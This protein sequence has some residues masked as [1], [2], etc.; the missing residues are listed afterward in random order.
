MNLA[1]GMWAV[2]EADELPRGPAFSIQ[3]IRLEPKRGSRASEN[4]SPAATP[5]PEPTAGSPEKTA[6]EKRSV[7]PAPAAK[8]LRKIPG[9]SRLLTYELPGQAWA[10]TLDP[11]VGRLTLAV[12]GAGFLAYDLTDLLNARLKPKRQLSADGF[13][14][15][16]VFKVWE[17]KRLVL[18]ATS[19]SRGI[20]LWDAASF[21]SAGELPIPK[22]SYIR[23][24]LTSSDPLD[25][26]V[27]AVAALTR[28]EGGTLFRN[29]PSEFLRFN[30]ESMSQTGKFPFN[31]WDDLEI[32]R[33]GKRF[34]TPVDP[35]PHPLA[36]RVIPPLDDLFSGMATNF[37]FS[38]GRSNWVA[39][40][41][42]DSDRTFS[43]IPPEGKNTAYVV[44]A[45]FEDRPLLAAVRG[46]GKMASLGLLSANT[47]KP[48]LELPLPEDWFAAGKPS[49]LDGRLRSHDSR[50][51]NVPSPCRFLQAFHDVK[52]DVVIY[53]IDQRLVLLPLK[54]LK[55]P[56]EPDLGIE[57][58][59]PPVAIL[60]EELRIPIKLAEA[61]TQIS[62][63]S[64]S[65]K[66][67]IAIEGKQLVWT[68]TG[69]PHR[70]HTVQLQAT[71]G[72]S[73]RT[74][75]ITCDVDYASLQ[76]PFQ[77]EGVAADRNGKLAVVWG[78]STKPSVPTDVDSSAQPWHLAV[79]DLQSR[80]VLKQR[81]FEKPVKAAA[82]GAVGVFV[83]PGT[84]SNRPGVDR[85][86][87]G[88]R[89][90]KLDPKT[91]ETIGDVTTPRPFDD[92][93][94][95]ADKYLA[96]SASAKADTLEFL[97]P[98]LHKSFLPSGQTHRGWLWEGVVWD[99][100]LETRR[101]ILFTPGER[102]SPQHAILSHSPGGSVRR[103]FSGYQLCAWTYR[104]N[105][106]DPHYGMLPSLDRPARL[107]PDRGDSDTPQVEFTSL[108]YFKSNNGAENTGRPRYERKYEGGLF[109]LPQDPVNK[110][111]GR[112]AVAAGSVL[113]S[114][115]DRLYAIPDSTIPTP[116]DAT[117]RRFA[118]EEIQSTLRLS[119]DKPTKVTYRAPGAVRY[120]LWLK[121]TPDTIAEGPGLESKTG[122]FEIEP[123]PPLPSGVEK[124]PPAER[125]QLLAVA[126]E[127]F[128]IQTGKTSDQFPLPIAAVVIAENEAG[129]SAGLV[130]S[131]YVER[132]VPEPPPP[133]QPA[134]D[135]AGGK[136]GKTPSPPAKPAF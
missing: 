50:I 10:A 101:L 5:A 134:S 29:Q 79:V 123:P 62:L 43:R 92:I 98:P 56:R 73:S 46:D 55:L 83:V 26:N 87:A 37:R 44:E 90:L 136:P 105:D 7:R 126:R 12:D 69:Q 77:I 63:Q 128:L 60:G 47:Q 71:Q 59:A 113:Y 68:P 116:P 119:A 48:I 52:R 115:G 4:S 108:G 30:L 91:L 57:I 36:R 96:S 18:T 93:Q 19:D 25:P 6:P 122:E 14:T 40:V 2:V 39:P 53:A 24:I 23:R 16:C 20:N 54:P 32:S 88:L 100:K 66:E 86:R 125:E 103:W 89:M 8:P 75:R 109:L 104:D 17:K 120:R 13:P 131:Y 42:V 99:E 15:S 97:P 78:G 135:A 110:V 3:K 72:Q 9:D 130:H 41:E 61:E 67:K 76:L 102:L 121:N 21:E 129:D 31:G 94:L 38:E 35:R 133:R 84:A 70:G 107:M 1:A 65:S 64:V 118:I 112:F 45:A 22:G 49:E 27:Y 11:V 74:T 51:P 114:R 81:D 111:Q 132:P 58:K 124:M 28:T 127:N 80:E 106:S 85:V 33:D 34:L 117:S 82:I 95:I